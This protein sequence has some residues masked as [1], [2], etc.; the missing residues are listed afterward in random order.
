LVELVELVEKGLC[1]LHISETRVAQLDSL[2]P[3]DLGAP[4]ELPEQAQ[5]EPSGLEVLEER[6][7]LALV[8]RAV[9]QVASQAVEVVVAQVAS[10]VAV[11]AEAVDLAV[12]LGVAGAVVELAV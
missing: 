11:V 10:Q 3:A 2:E 9:R 6:V 1:S 5:A 8:D 4:S 7:E 12:G